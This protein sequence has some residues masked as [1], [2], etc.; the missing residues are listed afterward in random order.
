MPQAGGARVCVFHKNIANMIS[1][2]TSK[3]S[4]KGLNIENMASGSKG[5]YAYTMLE[6]LVEVPADVA[7]DIMSIDGVLRVRVI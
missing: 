7:D 3:L 2:I 5:E 4:A 1:Q 6:L